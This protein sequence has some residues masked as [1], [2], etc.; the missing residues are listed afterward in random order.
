M[1]IAGSDIEMMKHR[2][3]AYIEGKYT[4]YASLATRET[5]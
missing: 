4:L 1:Y 5:T 3:G 2:N